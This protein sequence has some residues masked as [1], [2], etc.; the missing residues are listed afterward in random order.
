[1]VKIST[2]YVA[3]C[4]IAHVVTVTDVLWCISQ[5]RFAYHSSFMCGKDTLMHGSPQIEQLVCLLYDYRVS[6]IH[7]DFMSCSPKP[8]I[9]LGGKLSAIGAF[10]FA[11]VVVVKRFKGVEVFR[12]HT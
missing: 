3:A 10:Y 9:W 6:G 12:T 11:S 8:W 4:G 2:C 7:G 5:Q 1:M